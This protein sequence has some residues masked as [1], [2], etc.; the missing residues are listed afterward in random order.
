MGPSAR[1]DAP[2]IE[3]AI[4]EQ[5]LASGLL[6]YARQAGVSIAATE[7][8]TDGRRS[9]PVYGRMTRHAALE[10]LLDGLPLVFE[11][12]AQNSVRVFART[13]IDP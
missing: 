4:P 3:F 2:Q 9:R 6:E 11:F 10:R 12:S 8:L 13:E 1:P 5:S 7:P